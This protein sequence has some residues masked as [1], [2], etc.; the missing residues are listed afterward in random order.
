MKLR[1]DYIESLSERLVQHLVRND[2]LQLQTDP[3]FV[4]SRVSHTIVQDLKVEDELDEEVRQIL[5][6]YTQQMRQQRI[7][8]HEMFQM[9][10]RKLV[11][12]RNLIL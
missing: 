9:V 4:Q 7:E 11:K 8:Y 3:K 6:S 10:K 12:E 2:Y 5:E 1:R